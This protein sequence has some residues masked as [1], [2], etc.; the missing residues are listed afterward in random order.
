MDKITFEEFKEIIANNSCTSLTC[1]RLGNNKKKAEFWR[2]QIDLY[3][4]MIIIIDKKKRFIIK[5]ENSR[6][7]NITR[8]LD[9]TLMCITYIDGSYIEVVL[10]LKTKEKATSNGTGN[11]S[12]AFL[13]LKQNH[14]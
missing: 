14:I 6:V 9:K 7:I 2:W 10:D 3:D 4:E 8:R 12:V 5:R 11:T 13:Q 1:L